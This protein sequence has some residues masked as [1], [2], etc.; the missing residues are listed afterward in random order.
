MDSCNYKVGQKIKALRKAKKLKQVE[1]GQIVGLD[2]TQISNIETGKTAGSVSALRSISIA[3]D[4][5][6]SELFAAEYDFPS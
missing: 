5:T 3:L 4:T 1:L 2:G 6:L